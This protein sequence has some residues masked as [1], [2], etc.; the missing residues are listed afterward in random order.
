MVIRSCYPLAFFVDEPPEPPEPPK[1]LR[2]NFS[3]INGYRRHN[4]GR[5]RAHLKIALKG[6]RGFVEFRGFTPS[7]EG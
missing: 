2:G 5:P 7:S 6:N 4:S 1:S 3:T